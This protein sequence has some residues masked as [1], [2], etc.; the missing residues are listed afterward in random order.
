[1]SISY[2]VVINETN[3]GFWVRTASYREQPEIHFKHELLLFLETENPGRYLGW[4][5]MKNYNQLIGD[6]VRVPVIKVRIIQGNIA[7]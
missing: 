7:F 5:T 6:K 4:S 1:M 3:L 2:T